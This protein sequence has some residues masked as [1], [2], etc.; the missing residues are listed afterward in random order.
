[1]NKEMVIDII[2]SML[3][4]HFYLKIYPKSILKE[5]FLLTLVVDL[6]L[7]LLQESL[8]RGQQRILM[9]AKILF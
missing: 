6:M 8:R 7:E 1:M 5:Q 2:C 4:V 3:N 9:R